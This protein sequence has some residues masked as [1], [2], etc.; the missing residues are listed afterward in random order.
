[1]NQVY[2]SA[3]LKALGWSLLDSLWQMG[4]LWLL[5]LTF[6][7]NG[8]KFTAHQRHSLALLSLAGGSLWFVI[9]LVINIYDIAAAPTVITVQALDNA[10]PASLS[11]SLVSRVSTG[12]E[13]V[14]PFLSA[15][16]L[17]VA[18]WLFIRF[19]RQYRHTQQL[20]TTDVKKVHPE[21]RVFLQRMAAQMGVKKNVQIW[22]SA[23]VDAPLTLGFWKPVILLPVAAVNHLS[24]QQT[25]AII[26]HELYH[27]KRNDYLINLLVA[28]ADVILFFNPFARFFTGV[29]RRERENSCDD[30]VLQFRYDGGLYAQSLLILEKS[31]HAQSMGLAIAATGN[32]PNRNLL[33]NRVKRILKQEPV[34]T[35]VNHK[36]VAFLFSAF[37]IGFIGWYNPGKVIVKTIRMVSTPTAT[38]EFASTTYTTSPGLEKKAKKVRYMRVSH[39]RMAVVRISTA[40]KKTTC[41][42]KQ[43]DNLKKLLSSLTEAQVA[44]LVNQSLL[45]AQPS[46]RYVTNREIR[47]FSLPPTSGP[48]PAASVAVDN[49]PYVPSSS[50][51]Y[52]IIEDTAMP[53]RYIITQSEQKAKES[54]ETALKALHEIDWMKLEKELKSGKKD[55]DIIHLQEMI[56]KAFEELN[57]EKLSSESMTTDQAQSEELQRKQDAWRLALEK[58]MKD[59]ITTQQNAKELQLQI[60]NERLQEN[61]KG[62]SK[63][64]EKSGRDSQSKNGKKVKKVVVI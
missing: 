55:V 41:S 47:E 16:Y 6:T 5:Y 58:F 42:N 18:A 36:L 37:L 28:C 51:S 31:R 25:E 57:W 27:I 54:M 24:L 12:V 23:V 33:L 17:L 1:M 60:L 13:P 64:C 49:Y 44:A 2:Q 53:K 35:P 21:L 63:C 14:L 59:R 50:F 38:A 29:I 4:I 45:A 9:T 30:M 20:L 19:F 15:A 26:L 48:T 3:F 43:E 32:Q 40:Q 46:I 34:K 56:K 52:Q 22:L 8:K 10:A 11:Y 39:N 62:K 61:T 7:A